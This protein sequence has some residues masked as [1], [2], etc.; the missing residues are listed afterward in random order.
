ML[1]VTILKNMIKFHFIF[2]EDFTIFVSEAGIE[3]NPLFMGDKSDD[4]PCP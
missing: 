1:G 2:A 3:T 4:S